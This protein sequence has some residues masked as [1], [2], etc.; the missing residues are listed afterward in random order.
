[1]SEHKIETREGWLAARMALLEKEKEFTRARDAL[2]R[3][4]QAMPWERV[5]KSYVFD[6]LDGQKTLG[7]LFGDKSQLIVQHFM[8]G[9][10]WEEGCPSC[11]FW[12]DNFE[13]NRIHLAARDVALVAV[14]TAAPEK[15]DAYRR[16]MGW[17]VPWYSAQNTDFNQDFAVTVTE[18][19]L[20]SGDPIYNFGTLPFHVT[21]M[22]GLSVFYKDADGTIFH[23]YSTYAR[24][25]DMFNAAYHLL[26]VVPK[27]RDEE[28]L[29]Y[30]MAWLRRRDQYDP[31][32]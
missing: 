31:Q 28:G 22:P 4:R 10:D 25:L 1:M 29:P 18:A 6:G 12:T 30:G 23:T 19:E 16:R 8:F 7:D 14:S 21:E 2:T 27:G 13:R 32:A 17:T 5:E 3:A 26:D 20:A 15:L 11:S 24:G 9:A